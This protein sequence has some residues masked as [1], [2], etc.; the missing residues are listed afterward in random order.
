MC[1]C[2]LPIAMLIAGYAGAKGKT[3]KLADQEYGPQVQP[4][5]LSCLLRIVNR[6]HD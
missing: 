3:Q 6:N 5:W 2:P 4:L 1:H